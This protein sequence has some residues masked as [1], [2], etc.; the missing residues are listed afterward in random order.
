MHI[1]LTPQLED[2]VRECVQEGRFS[3]TSEVIREGLRLLIDRENNQP[4]KLAALQENIQIGLEQID[5]GE[6]VSMDEL[7]TKARKIIE[8]AKI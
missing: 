3:S 7:F 2:Y 4:K 5:R 8:N 6:T 1:S